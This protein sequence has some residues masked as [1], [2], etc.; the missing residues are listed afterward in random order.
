MTEM[1]TVCISTQDSTF[2]VQVVYVQLSQTNQQQMDESQGTPWWLCNLVS[3]S[4][5][6]WLT[7]QNNM[8]QP[9]LYIAAKV[10]LDLHIKIKIQFI[11]K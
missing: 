1:K 11:K 7:P 8:R 9:Q 6:T 5:S 4:H 10:S 2:K 3:W